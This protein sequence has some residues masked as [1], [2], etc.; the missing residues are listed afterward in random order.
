MKTIELMRCSGLRYGEFSDPKLEHQ[1]IEVDTYSVRL[2]K[3]LRSFGRAGERV[4]F[5]VPRKQGEKK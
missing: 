2:E 3:S 5:P 1:G 4:L